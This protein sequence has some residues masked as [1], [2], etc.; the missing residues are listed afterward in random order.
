MRFRFWCDAPLLFRSLFK[1]RFRRNSLFTMMFLPFFVTILAV[2]VSQVSGCTFVARNTSLNV[3]KCSHFNYISVAGRHVPLDT[4]EM[5]I[6]LKEPT[7]EVSLYC[8]KF[9]GTYSWKYAKKDGNQIRVTFIQGFVHLEVYWCDSLDGPIKNLAYV[10]R[11]KPPLP[12]ALVGLIII[13]HVCT[14]W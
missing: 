10:A 7:R 6:Q 12:L 11:S 4:H 1:G 14:R 9:S 5:R 13:I 2:L 8:G 3:A